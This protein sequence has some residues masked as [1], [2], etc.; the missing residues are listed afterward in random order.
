MVAKTKNKARA[1]TQKKTGAGKK[2][3][4]GNSPVKILFWKIFFCFFFLLA[5]LSL[6]SVNPYDFA[7]MNGGVQGQIQNWIGLTGAFLSKYLLL[8]FGITSYPI[9]GFFLLIS[10]QSFRSNPYYKR[11]GF[12]FCSI[13]FIIGFSMLFAMWPENFVDLTDKL[14]IGRE[15]SPASALSGGTVGQFL[16]SPPTDSLPA[17]I[18]RRYVGT[19]GCAIL[20]IAFTVTGTIFMWQA[21][22]LEGINKFFR[23]FSK[24]FSKLSKLK[25]EKK[26]KQEE[27]AFDTDSFNSAVLQVKDIEESRKKIEKRRAA[28]VKKEPEPEPETNDETVQSEEA[29]PVQLKHYNRNG[30][31]NIEDK[32]GLKRG[33]S[34][35]K[36]HRVNSKKGYTLPSVKLLSDIKEVNGDPADI[37]AIAKETLQDTLNSFGVNAKVTDAVTG[38]RVTRLEVVPAPGIRVQKI[39]SLE[40]NI[41]LDL[42]AESIRILA[43]I[44]GKDAVGIEIPNTSSSLVSFKGIINSRQWT[45]SSSELPIILGK[46]V[47]G[48]PVITDLARAPHLLIAGATGSGKSVCV[49]TLLMSL[50]Y[51]YTPEELRLIMVD[52][53]VVEFEMYKKL[54]HLITPIV[55]E[56]K[57]VPLALRWAINEME[58]RYRILARARVKNIQGYNKRDKSKQ[59]LDE[60]NNPLPDKIPYI[61]IIIDELADIIMAAKAEVE[62]SIARIA[63]KA[64]AVGIHLVLATQRPSVQI[65]TGVIKANLPTRIAFR[66]TSVTDSRVILDHKGAESLLGRGDMLFIPPGSAKLERIQGAMLDDAELER[67]VEYCAEQMEQDFDYSVTSGGDNNSTAENETPELNYDTATESG[68]SIDENLIKQAVDIIKKERKASTSYLQRRL[69]I[70][71]NR[72]AEI[73]DILEDRGVIGPQI[74]SA[75][76]EILIEPGE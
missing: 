14:G 2:Q 33:P 32:K 35:K 54:P 31:F 66:V 17:G 29:P 8:L 6:I 18:L 24:I 43:P 26:P 45:R 53:K 52:P 64:R 3:E 60:D 5:F 16:S 51:K 19:V 21:E 70:G 58:K 67:T 46:N 27:K 42:K 34:A 1:T 10:I 38:P 13:S 25:R 73:M 22:T 12:I 57:K 11:K 71:Y 44:P 59:I 69:K 61:V 62:T 7:L 40:S 68:S 48:E 49:N 39:S 55:N 4:T 9:I 72:A 56:P 23:I 36:P 63:Q 28:R 37:I 75:R 76:R 50:L 41:K 47:A 15:A 74:G 20:A 30:N 65:I